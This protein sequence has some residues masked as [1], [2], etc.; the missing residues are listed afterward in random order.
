MSRT[1][2]DVVN[3][4]NALAKSYG[5]L[6]LKMQKLAERQQA[7][8]GFH[9]IKWTYPFRKAAPAAPDRKRTPAEARQHMQQTL[10]EFFRQTA[11][12]MA[13][14]VVE[15]GEALDAAA[16]KA[17]A[18]KPK[19]AA[20]LLNRLTSDW[21]QLA[22]SISGDLQ[23]IAQA[24]SEEA[25]SDLGI[26]D[27]EVLSSANRVAANWAEDHAA[28]LIGKKRLP[29]GKLIDN[30]NSRFDIASTTR[31]DLQRIITEAFT[32]GSS[33]DELADAIRDS[34]GFSN[35]RAQLI[36][37]T[38]SA[39]A[40]EEGLLTGWKASGQVESVSIVMSADHDSDDE[41][42][43]WASGGPYALDEI[44]PPPFHPRCSCSMVI[45]SLTGDEDEEDKG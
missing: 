42:D 16:R 4:I 43:E 36:A 11:L 15:Y 9:K 37:E 22:D 23:T 33:I 1:L 44:E 6:A 3:E 27:A 21:D 17:D 10:E 24:S 7:D 2:N 20:R 39:R 45:A 35:E 19:D 41:C 40:S 18:P 14:R 28:E 26:D 29:S 25:L 38:E 13:R 31:L 30:P 5:P 34:G 32:N 12:R 8:P